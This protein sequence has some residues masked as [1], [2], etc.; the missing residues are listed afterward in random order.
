MRKAATN[1]ARI[2]LSGIQTTHSSKRSPNS[3]VQRL[4]D[5]LQTAAAH[6]CHED[7]IGALKELLQERVQP[8]QQLS[9]QVAR[10]WG[11]S[12]GVSTAVL[13]GSCGS[14]DWRTRQ[15][16]LP[17]HAGDAKQ[18]PPVMSTSWMLELLL[19]RCF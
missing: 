2:Q 1:Q 9:A 13:R 14:G 7:V 5:T 16:V 4:C 10:S 19:S 18:V 11:P 8:G 3:T 6:L 15:T 17:L 12:D